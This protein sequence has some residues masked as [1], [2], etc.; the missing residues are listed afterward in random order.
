MAERAETGITKAITLLGVGL[1]FCFS[2][3]VFAIYG[4]PTH[5]EIIAWSERSGPWFPI[6]F[7]IIGICLISLF[8]PKSILSFA[9]GA[10]FGTLQG[11]TLM[12]VVA[13]FAAV[14]NYTVARWL[15]HDLVIRWAHRSEKVEVVRRIAKKGGFKAHLLLR[16]TPVPTMLVSY[17][18]G[19]F[20]ARTVPFTVAAAVAVAGQVLWVHSGHLAKNLAEPST[21]RAATA[22]GLAISISA[23]LGL[24]WYV[25]RA[26]MRFQEER[27][28]DS[29]AETSRV[30]DSAVNFSEPRNTA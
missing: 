18:C 8:V 16:L 20:A 21:S 2:L 30:Q 11:T 5:N 9:A 15:M 17:A 10:L 7:V 12:V 25:G 6:A 29:N 28:A 27:A 13:T 23:S 26:A 4:V 19:A 3:A 1:L 24:L 14:I 22:T